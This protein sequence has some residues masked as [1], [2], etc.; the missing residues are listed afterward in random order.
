M[1]KTTDRILMKKSLFVII[2]A[3]RLLLM[4]KLSGILQGGPMRASYIIR[5]LAGSVYKKGKRV[6]RQLF[7][8]VLLDS[9]IL[10]IKHNVPYNLTSQ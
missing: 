9:T 10:D 4:I 5:Q 8:M 2:R 3:C 7:K 1:P 6:L